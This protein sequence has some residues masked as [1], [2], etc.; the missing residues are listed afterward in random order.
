MSGI[1][2]SFSLECWKRKDAEARA[3]VGYIP[4][5]GIYSQG[6]NDE[7]LRSA[8][9]SAAEMFL[10]VCYNKDILGKALRARGM[11]KARGTHATSKG[12]QYIA[13]TRVNSEYEKAFDVDVPVDL[14]VAQQL[15]AQVDGVDA[16]CVPQ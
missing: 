9:S 16:E 11:N 7:E 14:L 13:I 3:I 12:G 6:R 5:L 8:L 1:R 10:V 15:T 2:V 4:V